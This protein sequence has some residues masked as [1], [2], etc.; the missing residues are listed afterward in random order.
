MNDYG[1]LVEPGTIRYIR[2]VEGPIERVWRY[3]TEP[4]LRAT[5]IGST[6]IPSNVGG[7][8]RIE[9]DGGYMQGCVR[10][11]DPPHV[12]EYSW[13]QQTSP[14]GP[15]LDSVVRFELANDGAAVRL[16]LTHIALP[17]E[18]YEMIGAGWHAHLDVLVARLADREIESADDIFVRVQSAYADLA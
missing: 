14:T 3:L 17:R 5:W 9:W 13:V 2:H 10:V 1:T 11:Y 16:T 4:A 6:A 18:E 7:T 15:I 12:L 8:F